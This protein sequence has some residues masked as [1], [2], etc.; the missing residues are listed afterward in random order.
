[1]EQQTLDDL[2]DA[3]VN[4]QEAEMRFAHENSVYDILEEIDQHN[5]AEREYQVLRLQYS[6]AYFSGHP[7]YC[8]ERLGASKNVFAQMMQML[9]V[10][11]IVDSR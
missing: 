1:M 6:P 8:G 5:H 7:L 3:Y 4:W 2:E 9:Y 10:Q 11:W